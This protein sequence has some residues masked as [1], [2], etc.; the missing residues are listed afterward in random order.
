MFIATFNNEQNFWAGQNLGGKKFHHKS[1]VL[2]CAFDPMSGRVVASS[3]ADNF[4]FLT[5]CFMAD[6]DTDGA[7]PFG[8]VSSFG[9]VLLKFNSDGWPNTVAFTPSAN[10]LV[11]CT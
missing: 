6:V 1:S 9:D 5:T 8:Q 2:S 3:S 10:S 4:V 11:Y 7:G